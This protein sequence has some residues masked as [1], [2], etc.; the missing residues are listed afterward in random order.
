[1]TI[2]KLKI[3]KD[4]RPSDEFVRT[5]S[6]LKLYLLPSGQRMMSGIYFYESKKIALYNIIVVY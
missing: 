5:E 6:A 1:M 4:L 2:P 3:G